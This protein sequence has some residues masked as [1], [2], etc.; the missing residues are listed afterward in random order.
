MDK[1]YQPPPQK[2]NPKQTGAEFFFNKDAWMLIF[3]R[4]IFYS[5]SKQVHDKWRC[6]THDLY[7]QKTKITVRLTHW[8]E[9]I[10][11]W[12]YSMSVL[13]KYTLKRNEGLEKGTIHLIIGIY[14]FFL[15]VIWTSISW[16]C[17]PLPSD[18]CTTIK[19]RQF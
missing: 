12:S 5:T 17:F 15:F 11:I 14:E 3:L 2:K 6:P 18:K 7:I 4:L 8:E 13:R 16:N 19:E 10:E 1:N 9:I